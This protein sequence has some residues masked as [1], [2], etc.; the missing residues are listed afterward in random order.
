MSSDFYREHAVALPEESGIACLYENAYLADAYAIILPPDATRDPEVIARFIGSNPAPWVSKLMSLRDFLVSFWGLK[1]AKKLLSSEQNNP[2]ERVNIFKI[3]QK[4]HNEI[5]LGE[6]DKHL[7]FRVSVPL[8]TQIISEEEI[9]E[10]IVTTVVH[11]H[12]LLGRSYINIIKPFHCKVV[13]SS[14]RNAAKRGWPLK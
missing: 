10:L 9:R 13:R 6:D 12:N 3:Y 5:I 14:I 4:L 8:Q 1:T 11:C 2:A 7:D